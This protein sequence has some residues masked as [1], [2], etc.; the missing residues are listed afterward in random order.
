MRLTVAAF[1]VERRNWLLACLASN[2]LTERK[3]IQTPIVPS[4]AAGD[5]REA[6]RGF[7]SLFLRAPLGACVQKKLP[8]I[9]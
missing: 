7:E 3:V 8:K 2:G 5:G 1:R 9:F 6:H 4:G